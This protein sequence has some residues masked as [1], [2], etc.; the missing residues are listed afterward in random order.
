MENLFNALANLINFIVENV[1]VIFLIV[2]TLT[3][4]EIVALVLLIGIMFM[5]IQ[6][7]YIITC[8]VF[9]ILCLLGRNL[10]YNR[11]SKSLN[12]KTPSKPKIKNDPTDPDY[13]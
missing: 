12:K 11:V 10:E 9:T 7:W 3:A 5:G 1:W 6:P 13:K 8:S 4:S 2:I